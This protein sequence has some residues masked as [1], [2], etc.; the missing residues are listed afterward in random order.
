LV[1]EGYQEKRTPSLTYRYARHLVDECPN[2]VKI[3]FQ[4][5]KAW[6][7]LR[8]L[9]KRE[10]FDVVH[11]HSRGSFGLIVFFAAILRRPVV[12]TIHTR[13]R[14][15]GMYRWAAG[16]RHCY[17]VLIAEDMK[18]YY[19]IPAD[20]PRVTVIP[21]ACSQRFFEGALAIGQHRA[22]PAAKFR[23]IGIGSLVRW[24]NWDLLIQALDLLAPKLQEIVEFHLWGPTL[25]DSDSVAFSA[26]LHSSIGKLGL[27]NQV[28]L[29]GQTS[30]IH[31][32][33]HDADWLVH[34]TTNEP[35][36]VGIAEAI[37]MGV[38]ALVS[39]SG[40]PKYTVKPGVNGLHFRPGDA[41]DLAAKLADILEGRVTVLPPAEL[42]E[43]VR[44][45]SA[46]AMVDSLARVYAAC[47]ADDGR[48]ISEN[49]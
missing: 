9:L 35:A 36:G 40:G 43:S 5:A 49:L 37:A 8:S 42:R 22:N 19:G 30:D 47:L 27:R 44:S 12:F 46:A 25:D 38:P 39:A 4:A 6:P 17:T 10:P 21:S 16:L 24:K 20:S 23:L 33:L 1:H 15:I 3:L 45:R 28:F 32:A 29:H 7:G 14:R 18:E 13:A 48:P 31:G 41:S 26:E 2:P 11:G 34:P